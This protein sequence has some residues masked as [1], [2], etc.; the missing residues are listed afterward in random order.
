[1]LVVNM[2]AFV[3]GYYFHLQVYTKLLCLTQI[4]RDKKGMFCKELSA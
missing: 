2:L 4:Y 1:M 3:L